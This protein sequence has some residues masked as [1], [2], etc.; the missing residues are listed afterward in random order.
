MLRGF[1]W[2]EALVILGILLLLFGASRL[3][4]MGQSLGKGLR[5]FKRG[6]SGQAD[7]EDADSAKATSNDTKGNAGQPS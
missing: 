4:Q 2:S 3:P 7:Q 6:I 5:E 1:G